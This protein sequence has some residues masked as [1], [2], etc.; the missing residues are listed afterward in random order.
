MHCT[1][2]Q[3]S[4]CYRCGTLCDTYTKSVEHC[5]GVRRM[6][7]FTP[8]ELA[9][10]EGLIAGKLPKEIAADRGSV[11]GPVYYRIRKLCERFG[12]RNGSSAALALAYVAYK[13][14][15]RKPAPVTWGRPK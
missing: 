1:F 13:A 8:G 5:R 15:E 11:R 7:D 12:I 6:P 14:G 2:A 9:V 3:P 4:Y 10:L